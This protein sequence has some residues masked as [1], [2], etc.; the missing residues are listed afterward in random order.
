MTTLQIDYPDELLTLAGASPD[1]LAALAREA[2]V[3]RLYDQGKLSSGQAARLLGLTRWEFLD[4][5]GRYNVSVFDETMDVAAEA[6]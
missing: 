6:S 2:L 1:T 4:L 5:L 3:V